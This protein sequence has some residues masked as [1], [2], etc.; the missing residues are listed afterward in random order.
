MR[1]IEKKLSEQ[2]AGRRKSG[3]LRRLELPANLEDFCSNDYLGIARDAGFRKGEWP[4]A[5]DNRKPG[6][7]GS[8]LISGNSGLAELLERELAAFHRAESA[9][10]YTSGYTANLG[11]LPAVAGRGDTILYDQLVHASLRDGIRLSHARH[12]AFAH[13]DVEHLADKLS[14]ASG[15]VFIVVES[16]YSMDGDEAPLRQ[17]VELAET[18]GAALIVDE[19]HAT[20]VFG[21]QGEGLV[22][23]LGLEQRVWVRVHT[24]GKALGAHGAVVCGPAYL[25]EFLINFSRPFIYTTA[26]PDP[27]LQSVRAAY[28]EMKKAERRQQLR[29]RIRLFRESLSTKARTCFIPSRSAIQALLWP[30]NEK[31][32]NLAGRV[33]NAGCDVR[34]ILHPTVP[35]GAERLR[36]C[37]H[38]F[39]TEKAIEELTSQINQIINEQA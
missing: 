29:G 5:E 9:L 34:P 39:N 13:N 37:L 26:L 23:E 17:L 27:L 1:R 31:V 38:A 15:Q 25:R 35:E 3:A 16:V 8:R 19:A 12:F 32:R 30:G 36:I 24:F 7:T 14:R 21:P 22:V 18:S 6:S 28:A 11:L 4:A 2:L 10:L 20:G 33:R